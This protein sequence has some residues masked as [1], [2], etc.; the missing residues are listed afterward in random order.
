MHP[1]ATAVISA[2]WLGILTSISPCPLAGNIVAMSFLAKRV[3]STRTVLT[4][5]L[6]Y[7]LGRAGAY[8][9]LAALL[10]A[11]MFSIPGASN[12]LQRYMNKI[13]GP[14]LIIAG[15]CL[16]GMIGKS[17][18]G[19][20]VSEGIKKRVETGG[21]IAAALLGLLLA[22]SFCPV[23][24]AMFFAGLIPLAIDSE[25]RFL[26]PSIYGVGTALPVIV[27]AVLIA[28]SAQSVGKM[29]NVLTQI[30]R[31]ARRLTGAI[32]ILV[33][34]YYSLSYIFAV[35]LTASTSP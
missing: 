15:M 35:Q 25:S 1:L 7:T 28:T 6:A 20:I 27:F 10:I 13:L 33:G 24:A 22:M 11:G 34:I 18:G 17:I 4:S 31:W 29:F 23:S 32:F 16:L 9:V 30:E 2:V 19:S 26:L 14:V 21:I 5:C 8:F 3:T 12:F